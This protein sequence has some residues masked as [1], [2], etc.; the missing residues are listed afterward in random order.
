[1]ANACRHVMRGPAQEAQFFLQPCS[2]VRRL[3]ICP[4]HPRLEC[5][6]LNPV[7]LASEI[8]QHIQHFLRI[9]RFSAAGCFVITRLPHFAWPLQ[10]T[11]GR[12]Q[13]CHDEH[14]HLPGTAHLNRRSVT[15]LI[16]VVVV[17]TMSMTMIDI[18]GFTE[19]DIGRNKWVFFF[20]AS[21]NRSSQ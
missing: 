15:I 14:C 11:H 13:L 12:I 9:K 4:G 1:M 17:T 6:P 7:W 21:S 8:G 2:S 5:C 10:V 20:S 16:L 3:H 19:A 18:R